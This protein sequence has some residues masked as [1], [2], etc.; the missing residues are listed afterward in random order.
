M[1]APAVCPSPLLV[2]QSQPQQQQQQHKERL[3]STISPPRQSRPVVRGARPCARRS[4]S[5]TAIMCVVGDHSLL[6]RAPAAP[7][8]QR[9]FPLL[10]RQ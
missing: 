2:S 8:A 1:P 6:T 7:G 10:R 4:L 9:D 5:C 3:A